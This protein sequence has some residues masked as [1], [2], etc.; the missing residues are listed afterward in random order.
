VTTE[1]YRGWLIAVSAVNHPERD[2]WVDEHAA[3]AAAEGNLVLGEYWGRED[4]LPGHHPE[5]RCHLFKAETASDGL[6]VPGRTERPI[7][8]A[9][10]SGAA[11]GAGPGNVD[12]GESE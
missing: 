9:E 2:V 12:G 1:P 10:P 7:G 6:S 4:V 3:I 5:L 11:T 8:P